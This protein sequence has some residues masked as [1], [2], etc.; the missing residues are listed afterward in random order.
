MHL[1][2]P[3]DNTSKSGRGRGSICIL[4]SASSHWNNFD[5]EGSEERHK[6]RMSGENTAQECVGSIL[7]HRALC[8]LWAST[9]AALRASQGAQPLCSLTRQRKPPLFEKED[10][11][12]LPDMWTP[13]HTGSQT[14]GRHWKEAISG[15]CFPQRIRSWL[16]LQCA[17]AVTAQ[18]LSVP[19]CDHG[20]GQGDRLLKHP[21]LLSTDRCH[22]M[23]CNV[24]CEKSAEV[25]KKDEE[26]ISRD[27]FPPEL[28]LQGVHALRY[29]SANANHRHK[30]GSSSRE[31]L[32]DNGLETSPW[33][34]KTDSG[35]SL[36]GGGNR[37]E[38]QELASPGSRQKS[39]DWNEKLQGKAKPTWALWAKKPFPITNFFLTGDWSFLWFIC[40]LRKLSP[41]LVWLLRG[42]GELLCFGLW[43]VCASVSCTL[44]C[45]LE[46]NLAQ[47]KAGREKDERT[48]FSSS[49]L[50]C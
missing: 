35:S 3:Q 20:G 21:L 8:L 2:G 46:Q 23:L 26:K 16:C 50:S 14:G 19:L 37:E 30:L 5:C 43:P 9:G 44:H 4:R 1:T 38:G 17:S 22:H 12:E 6:L 33:L 10:S 28:H 25:Q 24:W 13:L 49:E 40:V 45:D 42:K 48:R 31:L 39:P 7:E 27:S 47:G 29:R 18:P 15:G 36:C 32:G 41:S 11:R 34:W